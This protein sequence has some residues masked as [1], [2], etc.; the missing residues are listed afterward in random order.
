MYRHTHT[1]LS[2]TATHGRCAM[3]NSPVSLPSPVSP[4]SVVEIPPAPASEACCRQAC[5]NAA[6][7]NPAIQQQARELQQSL[8]HATRDQKKE[9]Q[10]ICLRDWQTKQ[11]GWRSHSAWGLPLC[12]EAVR[13]CLSLSKKEF[14]SLVKDR[15]AG[16]IAPSA[17]LQST[18]RQRTESA[19]A[20]R[21]ADTLLQWVYESL[22]EG[23][24]EGGQLRNAK[25]QPAR[26]KPP[27][28]VVPANLI[29]G[30][31]QEPPVDAQ[32]VRWLAPHTTVAEMYQTANLFLP[33]EQ[34]SY[35]TFARQYVLKWQ[36]KL[37]VRSESQHSKCVMCE[38]FKE[39]RRQCHAKADQERVAEEYGAHLNRAVMEDRR[40]D[41]QLNLRA[42]Q[43]KDLLS[44]E[45]SGLLSMCIDAM[46]AA[47]FRCPRN[48]SASK[49]FQALWRPELHL[50]GC[51]SIGLIEEYFLSDPDMPKNSSYICHLVAHALDECARHLA[52]AG[53]AMPAHFR[54]HS[55]NATGEA[56]NQ[57]LMRFASYLVATEKFET[58]S[59]TQ[60]RVGH[61]HGLIDQRF[62]EVRK[63]LA[64][65]PLLSTPA[66][67]CQAIR[68]GVTPHGQRQ[69][70]ASHV[71]AALNWS[72]HFGKLPTET[73]GHTQTKG[74]TDA[75][76]EAVHSFQFMLRR[77]HEGAVQELSGATCSPQ[78]V[79]LRCQHYLSSSEDSQPTQVFVP[80]SDW[81]CLSGPAPEELL[82]RQSFS[83]RQRSE[84][85]KT[86]RCISQP[87]W[88]MD[89]SYLLKLLQDNEDNWSEDW[90]PPA[91]SW[92]LGETSYPLQAAPPKAELPPDALEFAAKRV[93]EVVVKRVIKR[94]RKE[95]HLGHAGAR[96]AEE[97]PEL[98]PEDLPP[99][100]EPIWE[101][102]APL[103]PTESSAAAG[104]PEGER[105]RDGALPILRRPSAVSR[106]QAPR[107]GCGSSPAG[108][109]RSGAA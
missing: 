14:T 43:T 104:A 46:D 22:A 90:Q 63:A 107:Q 12:A 30:G 54:L 33:D 32:D 48:I 6:A 5:L 109:P 41:S 65:S 106:S 96:A 1:H 31:A 50:V 20:S 15:E 74:K 57:T 19:H 29:A 69:L 25:E 21:A 27:T 72:D 39:Y 4:A 62:S 61:T 8:S 55:D 56:K 88:N 59:L 103:P 70:R 89:T 99:P 78:D 28:V 40:V 24:V 18:Q 58:V 85:S 66:E 45:R 105:G 98:A 81:A 17:K 44:E 77:N 84:F 108:P 26:A 94:Q 38:R 76:L 100:A 7:E 35:P 53:K 75:H 73:S 82:P 47:K 2:S 91:V 101:A 49:E 9:L 13:S 34:C 60:F 102:P 79:L 52:Q 64:E 80:H 83:K 87:P 92:A 97:P 37:R 71:T 16:R 10:L 51:L 86:A 11:G 3:V 67:F 95:A 23:L 36:Q 42:L 93:A 68:E